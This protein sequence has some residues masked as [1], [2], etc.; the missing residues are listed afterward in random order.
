MQLPGVF[1][2]Q[3]KDGSV[4]FRASV[5]YRSKHISLGSFS[6]ART[7]HQAYREA[8]HIL[9]D[10][11]VTFLSYHSDL[12]L[13]F[14][15]WVSLMNFRDN[16]LYIANPIYIRIRYFEYYLTQDT[17]L[18]FDLDDLF[19]Y[20][21]HK[22]MK[23][24]GR[25]FISDYGMQTGIGARYG[26][27]NYAVEGRD[28]RFVNGDDLD[29]RYENIEI[30]NCFHGVS[31]VTKAGKPYYKAKIHINGDYIIGYYETDIQAAIAYNK[32][33]DLLKKAGSTR[34]YVPNYMENVS[35]SLYADLYDKI[36]VSPRIL[37]YRPE[38]AALPDDNAPTALPS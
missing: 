5:T 29:F 7:A 13:P 2:A 37:S 38:S 8:L 20:S 12:S 15:K 30:I 27:K 21:S 32:A 36:P 31:R 34:Q 19:Y 22:I 14:G 18:K 24:G 10:K 6:S 17:V 28:F 11:T 33:I 3:K 16:G 35:P 23:R 9:N 26:I 1:T 25:L 4:Y